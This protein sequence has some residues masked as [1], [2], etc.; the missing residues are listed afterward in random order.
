MSS[1]VAVIE[2]IDLTAVFTYHTMS[3]DIATTL[4]RCSHCAR[5][6]TTAL[7]ALT[8]DVGRHRTTQRH[9]TMSYDVVQHRTTTSTCKL[10]CRAGVARSY[11][12]DAEIEPSSIS[13]S[14]GVHTAHDI[15]SVARCHTTSCDTRAA[16]QF[17][18]RSCRTMS[19]DIVRQGISAVV[20][21][22]VQCE[23]RLRLISCHGTMSSVYRSSPLTSDPRLINNKNRFYTQKKSILSAHLQCTMIGQPLL[24]STY[25]RMS[26]TNANMDSLSGTFMSGHST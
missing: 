23:H 8:H 26:R 16:R 20:R 17:A 14:S 22:R 15:V 9:R 21:C 10:P 25:V 13:A 3:Y 19:Y 5:H 18:C 1:G 7:D 11:D 2:H 24:S 6:R 4:K 12:T